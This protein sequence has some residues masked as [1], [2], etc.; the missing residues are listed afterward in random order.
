MTLQE[1]IQIT[2]D[3]GGNVERQFSSRKGWCLMYFD[4]FE[5]GFIVVK[6]TSGATTSK[7]PWARTLALGLFDYAKA[8]LKA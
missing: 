7:G 5:N 1:E 6:H 3:C 2:E 8:E 4:R